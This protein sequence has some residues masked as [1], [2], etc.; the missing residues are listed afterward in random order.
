MSAFPSD[1]N[2]FLAWF[3]SRAL[4]DRNGD[5]SYGPGS[6]VPRHLYGTYLSTMLGSPAESVPPHRFQRITAQAT[7]L[8]VNAASVKIRLSNGSTVAADR[9]VLALGNFPPLPPFDRASR[10]ADSGRYLSDPWQL[11]A[12]EPIPP[13]AAVVLI[14]AGLT[15]VD[16]T[17]ALIRSGHR[18]PLHAIS[19][20]GLQPRSHATRPPA[21]PIPPFTLGELPLNARELLRTFRRRIR[22]ERGA[23]WQ[24]VIDA[25]RPVTQELWRRTPHTERARFLRHLQAQWDVHRHRLAPEVAAQID[26]AVAAGQLH[27]HAGRVVAYDIANDGLNVHIRPRGSFGLATLAAQYA[28]NCTGPASD[29]RRI[30]DPLVRSLLARGLVRPD[31]LRLGLDVD[32]GLRTIGRDGTPS[33]RLYAAGPMTKGASWEITAVPDLRVQA[34]TLARYLVA[35]AHARSRDEATAAFSP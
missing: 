21:V 30:D 33:P 24:S 6:F 18:G 1:P 15:M 17:I 32:H 14:G 9:A 8:S 27:F 23:G 34:E 20:H 2:H 3:N 11:G 35:A 12:P 5:Q 13:D 29:Y 10:L 22:A 16:I 19:R 4:Q 26:K 25:L 7:D 28:I 31:P